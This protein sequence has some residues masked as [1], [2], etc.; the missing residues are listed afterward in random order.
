[1]FYSKCYNGNTL[2]NRKLHFETEGVIGWI[3]IKCSISEWFN[4][5]V[6]QVT[7]NA[8]SPHNLLPFPYAKLAF[9]KMQIE[10]L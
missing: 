2:I 7:G 8:C 6:F 9:Y 10:Q 5:S 3:I 4:R 1:M